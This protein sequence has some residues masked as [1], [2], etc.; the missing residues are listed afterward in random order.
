MRIAIAAFV[1]ALAGTARAQETAPVASS[2][3]VLGVTG[4]G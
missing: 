4:L 1:F 3:L 2:S